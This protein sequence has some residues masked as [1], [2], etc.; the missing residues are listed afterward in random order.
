MMKILSVNVGKSVPF[1]HTTP[2]VTGIFKEPQSQPVHIGTYGLE[3]DAICDTAHHGG[4][5]QAVYLYGQ[6]D[7]DFWSNELG[8]MIAPG[9]FGENL[10]VVNMESADF[11]IGD[12]FVIGTLIMEITSPRIPCRTFAAR[13]EDKYFVK[14]FH[15]ANRPGLYCRVLAEGPVSAGDTMMHIPFEGE[16]VLATELCFSWKSPNIDAETR[17]RF[18][19]TPVHWKVREQV[20][21]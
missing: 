3:N 15:D 1:E 9:T 16:K 20:L 5:D 10:T 7:Y 17:R 12:R 2:R 11:H 4:L 6:P 8:R 14:K 18:L 21:A 13:M 19:S